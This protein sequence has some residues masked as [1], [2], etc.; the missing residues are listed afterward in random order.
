V[1]NPIE[2]H[3]GKYQS[4]VT[5]VLFKLFLFFSFSSPSDMTALPFLGFSHVPHGYDKCIFIFHLFLFRDIIV[6]L[7]LISF[8][9]SSTYMVIDDGYR[10]IIFI[11]TLRFTM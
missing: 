1:E 7:F 2:S 6:H 8:S 10:I 3:L 11:T 9:F 5:L 4:D